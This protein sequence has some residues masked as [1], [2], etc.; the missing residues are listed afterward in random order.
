MYLDLPTL[1][2]ADSF[3]TAMAGGLLLVAGW[4]NRAGRMA[5]W[6]GCACLLVATSTGILAARQG[7]PDLV[8][9][10]SVGTLINGASALY[11]AAA[12]RTH[13]ASV[14][15]A[16]LFAG[17]TLWIALLALP[18]YRNSAQTQMSLLWAIGAA[19]SYAAAIEMWRGRA[20]VLKAR[21]PLFGLLL[22]DGS[23]CTAGVVYG[24]FGE[25][26]ADTL[27]PLTNGFG[28][29]YFEAFLLAV[30]GAF[31]IVALARDRVELTLTAVAHVDS[32]TGLSSR[33]TF[34][35]NAERSL[36][37]CERNGMPWSLV[38]FDL[39]HFKAVNDTYGHAVGDL[40]LRRFGEIARTILR[41]RDQVGRIG[42]EEFAAA[43]PDS[44]A[45][46]AHVIADRVRVAFSEACRVVDGRDVNATISGGVAEAMPG[47][48]VAVVMKA[49]DVELYRAKARGRNRI[50]RSERREGD[51]AKSTVIHVA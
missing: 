47:D 38:A 19:Y 16:G 35:E 45:A 46:V 28:L 25:I 26:S 30:G 15:P 22:L 21:W 2:V 13:K 40:V 11:W 3:V 33:A 34:L 44:S 24:F 50:E 27:P 41:G 10:A 18:G 20:E 31:F 6:W 48:A 39:D 17:A 51:K 14:P 49:A 29:I 4:Q 37:A 23:V 12:R 42:G 9:R 5:L 43:F 36:A 32:L 7:L 1:L 8:T